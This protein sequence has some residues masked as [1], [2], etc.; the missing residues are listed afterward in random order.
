[1]PK[2]F[3]M[4]AVILL[5]FL[6]LGGC[7]FMHKDFANYGMNYDDIPL[8]LLTLGDSKEDV[9]RKLGVPKNVVGSKQ[10]EKGVVEVWSYEK[11]HARFGYDKKEEEYFLYFLNGK[12]EQ[13]GRAGQWEVEA[14][15]LYRLKF[16]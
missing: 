6:L 4:R 9:A 2:E 15:H 1:M 7:T 8:H 3:N 13:W 5:L 16:E 10:F 14:V 12:L 11:W